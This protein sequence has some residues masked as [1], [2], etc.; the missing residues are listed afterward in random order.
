IE[1]VEDRNTK[2]PA[3]QLRDAIIENAFQRG[4][5]LLGCGK[6]TIRLAPPLCVTREEVDEA[7]EILNEVIMISEGEIHTIAA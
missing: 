3:E 2:K 6:S 7:L 1:F 4:L 5:I